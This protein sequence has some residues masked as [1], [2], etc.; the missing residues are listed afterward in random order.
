MDEPQ[1]KNPNPEASPFV[2][3]GDALRQA[4]IELNKPLPRDWPRLTEDGEAI[5]L[6]RS[7]E[8]EGGDDLYDITL[9]EIPTP[10]DLLR[11]VVHLS[12]KNWMDAERLGVF[13]QEV[14]QAKK[15]TI[16]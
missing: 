1:S 8:G 12:E 4:L 3:L 13:V 14:A 2:S 7:R 6:L 9:E 11:W 10:L 15:W 16:R 5:S